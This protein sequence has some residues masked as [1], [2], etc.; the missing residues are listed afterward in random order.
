M[1]H[2]I[3]E[4]ADQAD[5]II[6]GYAFTKSGRKVKVFNLNNP[7]HASVIINGEIMETNMDDIENVIVLDYYTENKRFME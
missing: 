7:G 6:N 3:K 2:S 5:M 1:R 4:I